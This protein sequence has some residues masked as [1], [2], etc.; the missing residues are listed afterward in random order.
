MSVETVF[1]VLELAKEAVQEIKMPLLSLDIGENKHNAFLLEFQCL[2]FG[3]YTLQYAPHCF[4]FKNNK[5]TK[6]KGAF[7]LEEEYVR[8]IVQYIKANDK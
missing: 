8:S 2:Y 1:K 6:T 3:P 5:W 7:D 4:E